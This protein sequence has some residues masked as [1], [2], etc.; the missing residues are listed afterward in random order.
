MPGAHLVDA[1]GRRF[2]LDHD[3][4]GELAPR[5]V[6]ARA[7]AEADAAGGA[8]LD[9]RHVDRF[10]ERF[11]GI[12]QMLAGHGL[13][14]ARD[15]LPVAPALH[16]AMGG[17]RTD[18]EGRTSRP[19]LWAVGEVA[20]TGV[21][22]ANRLASNS[23]LE[24]VVFADRVARA[25]LDDRG[26][27]APAGPM[28]SAGET[29]TA[30]AARQRSDPCRDARNHDGATWAWSVPRRRSATRSRSW[31]RSIAP[32]PPR[33]LAHRQSTA[34]RHA[35]HPGGPPAPGEP[36]GPSPRRLPTQDPEDRR[37]MTQHP[38]ARH[39]GA[40]PGSRGGSPALQGEIR[41]LAKRRNA[42]DPRAQLPAARGP[43][44][45]RLRRRLARACPARRRRPTRT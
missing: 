29:D 12:T 8:W 40:P 32:R 6:L 10:A 25:L 1:D 4:R 13:D 42:V 36:R 23:L 43:G 45:R 31:Q 44:R 18:L 16:Y 5:D 20:R 9:A 22:G 19:G 17:V 33:R 35:D 2:A 38:A 28:P 34:R 27:R 41:A 14:P 30:V 24:G 37:A 11:P 26:R 7:V 39:R 3:E 21:H 15:L